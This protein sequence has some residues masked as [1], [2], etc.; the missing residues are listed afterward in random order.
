[1]GFSLSSAGPGGPR[2]R[3]RHPGKR[4]IVTPERGDERTQ[5][6]AQPSRDAFVVNSTIRRPGARLRI[7]RRWVAAVSLVGLVGAL[8]SACAVGKGEGWVKGEVS[9]P[10]CEMANTPYDMNPDFFAANAVNG[11]MT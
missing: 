7:V 5:G 2:K 11:Q 4:P 8:A 10:E 3:G 9:M 6:D 1:M